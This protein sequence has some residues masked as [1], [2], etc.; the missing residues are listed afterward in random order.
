MKK[1]ILLILCDQL[2]ADALGCYGNHVV[3]TPNIDKL[4]KNG[5]VFQNCYSPTPVCMPARHS[6]FSGETAFRIGMTEN[7]DKPVK[8]KN[9]LAGCL[10]DLGYATAAVGKMHFYPMRAHHGFER[11]MLSEEMP[12]YFEDDDYL[13]FLWENGYGDIEHP[14]GVRGDQYYNPQTSQLPLH[15][16]NASWVADNTLD[17]I[18][19]NRNRSFF[20]VAS[21]VGPHPPFDAAPGYDHMY[22]PENMPPAC[23]GPH[24]SMPAD[25]MLFHQDD[26]KIGGVENYSEIKVKEIKAAYYGIITQIDCQIGR[27][28]EGL[29]SYGLENMT[30][31]YFTS[32]H[33]ELLGD[34]YGFGK[35]SYFEGA[36][37]IPLISAVP[38]GRKGYTRRLTSLI[39][40]YPSIL[41]EC[42][43][44]IP[45]TCDGVSFAGFLHNNSDTQSRSMLIAEYG[46]REEM[47]FM[48][49]DVKDKNMKYIYHVCGGRE[50]LYDLENDP[51]EYQNLAEEQKALCQYYRDKFILYYRQNNYREA[52][53]KDGKLACI[54]FSRAAKEGF[55]PC[56]CR[57]KNTN[58]RKGG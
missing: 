58:L 7:M 1:N 44:N 2:R 21:F 48:V 20:C 25:R 54:A 36:C 3:K 6:L 39:D 46:Q 10:C 13:R 14:H 35:R 50:E 34:H 9:P 29:K 27:I 51:S 15:L 40:L 32:D 16:H 55:P 4:A 56:I 11:M 5:M 22:S 17:Y 53:G 52:F 45:D 57:W 24:D 42:G 31:V 8:M 18:R 12:E 49:R 41:D 38:G 47:K 28:L 33:G 30:A 19:N 26:Y 37:K 43:G 23:V